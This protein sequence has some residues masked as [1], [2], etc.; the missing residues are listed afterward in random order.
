VKK[1]LAF[2]G[3]LALAA[4]GGEDA[5]IGDQISEADEV[6]QVEEAT[7]E[8][9]AGTYVASGEDGDM[10]S[11]LNLDGTYIDTANGEI[12]GEGT[13]EIVDNKACFSYEPAE[14]EEAQPA[15]CFGVGPVAEDGTVVVTAEGGEQMTMTKTPI[16]S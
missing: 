10:I 8:S 16:A 2:T 15:E 1:L 13:W 11:T 3:I 5:L 4:C 12:I 7:M 6:V 14:G 9:L